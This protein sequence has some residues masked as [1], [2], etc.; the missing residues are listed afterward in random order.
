MDSFDWYI[1]VLN[2]HINTYYTHKLKP[3]RQ[4]TA[5]RQ[6]SVNVASDKSGSKSAL[7]VFSKTLVKG[8]FLAVTI[9]APIS[10][11]VSNLYKT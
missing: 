1:A 9:Y 7:L 2:I 11:G 8:R 3:C 5:P 4:N 10:E 6:F